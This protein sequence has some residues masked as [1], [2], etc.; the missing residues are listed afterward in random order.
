MYKTLVQLMIELR[1]GLSHV[2]AFVGLFEKLKAK[3][4][5][6]G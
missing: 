6:S 1:C 3:C 2:N 5:Y 4:R